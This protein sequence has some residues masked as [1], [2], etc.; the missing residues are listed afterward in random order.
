MADDRGSG[1]RRYRE[2]RRLMPTPLGCAIWIIALLVLLVIL[3]VLFGGFQL[4]TK[5][6][7]SAP[8]RPVTVTAD[9]ARLAQL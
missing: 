2:R 1:H 5:A 8:V 3:S 9:Q 6:G 4:G 7:G